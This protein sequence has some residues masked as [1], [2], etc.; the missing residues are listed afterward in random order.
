MAFNMFPYSNF[1]ELNLDWI[2]NE[3]KDFSGQ[4]DEFRTRL[5]TI[6]E[7]IL[8]D[9]KKYTDAAIEEKYGEFQQQYNQLVI[10]FG[11]FQKSINNTIATFQNQFDAYTDKTTAEVLSAK[12]YT[13]VAIQLNNE[14]ILE[15]I[16]K[17]AISVRVLNPF[18]GE[19][20]SIQDM[21]DYLSN[22]HLTEA[23]KISTLVTRNNTV[24]QMIAY[25]ATCADL[26]KNGA[27]II[28]DRS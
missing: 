4:L 18:T 3:L 13:D 26:V 12:A 14:T 10:D 9:C 25:N 15:E 8:A 22:F 20:V 23:I 17:Q 1:H 2:M 24:A 6:R 21:I 7:G 5:D 11:N 16:S 28:V 19:R 27:N